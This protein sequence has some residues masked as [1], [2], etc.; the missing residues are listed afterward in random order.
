MK[1]SIQQRQPS[2][3]TL[4]FETA[5]LRNAV[6][7]SRPG[8]SRHHDLEDLEKKLSS[9]NTRWNSV[10]EQ[11]EDRS[12][13]VVSCYN[14]QR[15]GGKLYDKKEHQ[16]LFVYFIFIFHKVKKGI[17]KCHHLA[18]LLVFVKKLKLTAVNLINFDELQ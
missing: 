8:T 9:L 10:K 12:V 13:L 16:N 6:E 15:V 1:S 14:H 11:A 18:R 5:E 2:L 4:N 17:Y 7:Q 3:D